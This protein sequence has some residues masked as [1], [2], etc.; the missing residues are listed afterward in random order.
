METILRQMDIYKKALD[1]EN[2]PFPD[3]MPL[4]REL[5]VAP[6]RKEAEDLARPYLEAKYKVYHEWGQDKAMPKGD[7]NLNLDFDDLA[8]D[9]FLFGSPDEV[10]EQIVK[11]NETWPFVQPRA[12][13]FLLH[14]QQLLLKR[15][16]AE[17]GLVNLPLQVIDKHTCLG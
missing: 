5:F 13:L 14:L 4:M 11:F 2:K 9:R 16:D 3:E 10:T 6:S 1:D 7:D 17:D 12:N 15:A 8:R